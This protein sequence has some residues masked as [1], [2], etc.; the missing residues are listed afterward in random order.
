M[1]EHTKPL[2]EMR[3]V[4]L[5]LGGRRVLEQVD[6]SVCGGEIVTLVGPNGA[7]KST[8]VRVLLGLMEPEQGSVWLRPGLRIGYMPQRLSVDPVLPLTVRRFLALGGKSSGSRVNEVLQE[9]GAG[10]LLHAPVRSLSGGELQRVLLARAL[11]RDPQLLILDEPV[12]GVDVAGQTD[13]YRLI[14]RIRDRLHCGILMVS[15]DLHLVMATTD[16]VVC[17]N[18]HVCCSGPPE[19]VSG[20]P[21]YLALFGSS[22]GLAVYTHHHDHHHHLDGRIAPLE[23][24]G[25]GDD[26]PG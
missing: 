21:A 5:T 3:G 7:G 24:R 2:A 13:L 10:G 9:V 8:L 18:R 14:G 19:D 11:L 25:E 12:Q 26:R 17:L 23:G 22:P 15:H 16:R 1:D 6:I 20:D 4:Q